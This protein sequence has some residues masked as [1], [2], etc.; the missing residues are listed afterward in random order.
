M[1]CEIRET[2][3]APA[4]GNMPMLNKEQ[5]RYIKEQVAPHEGPILSLYADVNPAKPEN[6]RGAWLT[7]IKN[8]LKDL[9]LPDAIREEVLSALGHERRQEARTLALFAG[10][11]LFWLYEL[12]CELPIVDPAHGRAEA[13][14]GQPYVAP[15]LYALDEY[16]RAA[17][18]WMGE[19]WRVYEVFL[20]EIE[21]VE[22]SFRA[23][24]P[25]DW[26]RLTRYGHAIAETVVEPHQYRDRDRFARRMEAWASRFLKRL[27]HLVEHALVEREISRLVLLGRE[28]ATKDFEQYLSRGVRNRVIAHVSDLPSENAS[29]AMVLQKVAPVL[30]AAEREQEERLLEAIQAQPGVFG[31]DDV[32]GAWQ[33]GLLLAV[34]APWNLDARVW[35]CPHNWVGTSP[36]AVKA[37]CPGD[38]PAE[39]PLRD[40][41]ADLAAD[42]GTRLEFVRGDAEVRLLRDLGGLAGL[43]RWK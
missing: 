9:E 33:Q 38:T 30:E 6:A 11:D 31:L 40:I 41:I 19:T 17:V 37:L 16:E 27:A 7:R 28:E 10:K 24:A 3:P 26:K 14:W 1:V 15:L 20:G 2:K 23:V 18:L 5:A 21:E 32:L 25:E 36:E 34:A 12:H 29:P 22:A 8:T 42:F 35:R 4:G 13:R 39:T 43:M